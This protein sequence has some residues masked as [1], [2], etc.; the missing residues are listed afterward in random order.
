MKTTT[1]KAWQKTRSRMV[2]SLMRTERLREKP[3]CKNTFSQLN[4]RSRKTSLKTRPKCFTC[5]WQTSQTSTQRTTSFAFW[6]K[7]FPTSNTRNWLW[8]RKKEW[9]KR[10]D[11]RKHSQATSWSRLTTN[12][13]YLPCS[14]CTGSAFRGML[15]AVGWW[16]T[17]TLIRRTTTMAS[18]T[19]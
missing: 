17:T 19:P 8:R 4:S 15:W 11:I 6:I 12:Q 5:G 13:V 10:R 16:D 2:K 14:G 9:P 18:S 3:S 1:W 7:R